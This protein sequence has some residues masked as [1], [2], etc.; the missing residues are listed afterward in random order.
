M[1]ECVCATFKKTPLKL[2]FGMEYRPRS[3]RAAAWC[4]PSLSA[5][6]S[7]CLIQ[8]STLGPLAIYLLWVFGCS[9]IK[10]SKSFLVKLH[11]VCV[12][13]ELKG[14]GVAPLLEPGVG[15]RHLICAD[16]VNK[17]TNW[18]INMYKS[19]PFPP[20][21]CWLKNFGKNLSVLPTKIYSLS[22]V[23][24]QKPHFNCGHNIE[25]NL[26]KSPAI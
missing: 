17:H 22:P 19:P 18:P 25:H 14:Y 8:F 11:L 24:T 23:Q 21:L 20:P 10:S 12:E 4:P 26:V 3:Q 5:S 1:C 13:Q 9:I 16:N 2:L 7:L 6:L 15:I